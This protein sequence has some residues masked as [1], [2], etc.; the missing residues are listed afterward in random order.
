[1]PRAPQSK[2]LL[3]GRPSAKRPV[4]ASSVSR[5]GSMPLSS[6]SGTRETCGTARRPPA[7]GS[8]IYASAAAPGGRLAAGGGESRSNAAAMRAAV[9]AKSPSR[10]E[11]SVFSM[12]SS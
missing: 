11:A 2:A 10:L 6:D 5:C 3:A 9:A 12:L 4:L 1:M 7:C 8:Q